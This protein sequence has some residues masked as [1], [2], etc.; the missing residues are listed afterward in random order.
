MKKINTAIGLIY[1]HTNGASHAHQHHCHFIVGGAPGGGKSHLS[2]S[3]H[4]YSVAPTKHMR[5][6]KL[7]RL[8]KEALK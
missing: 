8:V 4:F 3:P 1:E 2:L 6:T 5:K 7:G